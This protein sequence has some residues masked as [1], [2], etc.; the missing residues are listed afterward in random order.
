M[1]LAQ[2]FEYALKGDVLVG[3]RFERRAMGSFDRL[4]K[5]GVAAQVG[6]QQQGVDEET[7]QVLQFL[8]VA[9]GRGRGDQEIFLAGVTGQGDQVG[10][11]RQ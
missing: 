8:S 10:R 7:D 3:G 5:A 2:G 6:P 1:A 11:Q 9:I 4:P